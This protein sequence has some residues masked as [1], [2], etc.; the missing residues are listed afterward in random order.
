MTR[1]EDVVVGQ[2]HQILCLGKSY[3][4]VEV[5]D[6]ANVVLGTDVID[7][8]VA[9]RP[10]NR[11]GVVVGSVVAH[12]EAEA[13]EGLSENA[14]DRLR[15]RRR[16][17]ECR[18]A[19]CEFHVAHGDP[20]R[21]ASPAAAIPRSRWPPW[22]PLMPPPQTACAGAAPRFV[23]IPRRGGPCQSDPPG[24]RPKGRAWR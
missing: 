14:L 2:E 1:I 15:E 3:Q 17:V 7:S 21:S 22:R 23:T 16:P 18:D 24:K 10:H 8:F 4:A 6:W 5:P 20:G 11:R 13:R 19:H 12:D 9:K